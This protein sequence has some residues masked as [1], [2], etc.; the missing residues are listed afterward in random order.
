MLPPVSPQKEH[1][2]ED[3][4][5]HFIFD[6]HTSVCHT[7]YTTHTTAYSAHSFQSMSLLSRFSSRA[8]P[9]FKRHAHC[10]LS[11]SNSRNHENNQNKVTPILPVLKHVTYR[12]EDGGVAVISINRPERRN[13]VGKSQ[14]S[15]YH[16]SVSL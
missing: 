8:S 5:H 6:N 10:R 3:T 1:E 15:I 16:C 7:H 13:A 12:V 11:T 14:P 2:G 4:A 9:C